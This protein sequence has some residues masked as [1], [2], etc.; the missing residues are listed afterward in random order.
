MWVMAVYRSFTV[1]L[2][3]NDYHLKA[4][5]YS[6]E[7][8]YLSSMITTN[9]KYTTVYF[10]KNIKEIKHTTKENYQTTKVKR[11]KQTKETEL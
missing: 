3:L 5:T 6:F 1:C 2:K 4:S 11:N 10:E 7:L 8:T 9:Q